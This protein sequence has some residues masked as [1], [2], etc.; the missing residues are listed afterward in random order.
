MECIHAKNENLE[1]IYQLA[2]DT[3][4]AIY[5]KYYPQDVVEYEI[6]RKELH[7]ANLNLRRLVY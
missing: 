6:M 7:T 2:R 4:T 5:P 3:V 1:E